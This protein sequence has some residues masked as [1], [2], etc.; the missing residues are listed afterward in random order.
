MAG[1]MAA[2]FLSALD[3]TVVS[4]AM[5]RIITDL[6][7]LDRFTWVV[8]AY[9]VASTTAVPI[10]GKLSDMYGR[11]SFLIGGI[12]IFLVGS[13]LAGLSQTMNQLI[14]F[15][16]VQGL[17]GGVMMAIAFVSVADLFPPADRGK[18]QGFI[19]ATFP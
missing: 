1:V 4:T 9:L 11:K 10:V 13:A 5:P 8:T 6:G 19:A 15:R 3:Q 2:L 7:G 17:G 12:V 14:V 16:A 18:Y